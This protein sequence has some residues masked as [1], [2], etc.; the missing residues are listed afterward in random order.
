MKVKMKNTL[1]SVLFLSVQLFA[2]LEIVDSIPLDDMSDISLDAPSEVMVEKEK[3]S[4]EWIQGL[5]DI[6]TG[7]ESKKSF[8]RGVLDGQQYGE[9]PIVALSSPKFVRKMYAKHQYKTQWIST[10][11]EINP[12]LFEMLEFI[13]YADDVGLEK[14]DYHD[15]EIETILGELKNADDMSQRD[16]NI[17]IAQ[18]DVLLSDAFF[19]VAKDLHEGKIDFVK[20][21]KILKTKSEEDEINYK[22]DNPHRSM[23]YQNLLDSV[24]SSGGL[25]QE[26]SALSTDNELFMQLKE[27]YRPYKEI[28]SEGGWQKIP[29]G[30]QLKL[31]M[32]SKKRVPL[33]AK[34]LYITGDID[35]YDQDITVMTEQM[36]EGLK[37]YQSRMGIWPSGVLT[38]ATRNQLNVS[39]QKRLKKIKLNL[40]RAR[41]ENRA[42]GLEYLFVNIPDFRMYLLKDG[43][44]DIGMRVVVGKPANPTPIFD[45]KLSYI[46]LNPTWS[47]PKSIVVDEM[48]TKIQEDPDYLA[49]RKFKLYRGWKNDREEIDAFDVDWWQYDEESNL[50]FS[51]VRDP[52]KGNP[53]GLVK[54]MFPNKYAVYMHDTPQKKLFKNA[55]RAYSHG[56][57]RLHKPQELLAY[58]SEN[59]TK[60]SY[61]EVMKVQDTQETKSL[62]LNHPIDVHI[63][64]YTAWVDDDGFVQFRSDIYGYDAIQYKLLKN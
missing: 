20:F 54:F 62:V 44:K 12:N 42:F 37:H 5:G 55:K 31:G 52:G 30:K 63:R 38:G 3:N 2:Q 40:E 59:F 47:V 57:I 11:F 25:K 17:A 16:R 48:L 39:V 29:S 32:I 4:K 9:Y 13:K 10:S 21:S 61:D 49:T 34:R 60:L 15:I 18:I 1:F 27:A 14:K 23:N 43:M 45:S 6:H 53:L 51:F 35:S 22:W 64:Y 58:M 26:L 7:I 41:W 28:E 33:M 46:V 36:K 56:C 8:L 50:P 19:T 24:L